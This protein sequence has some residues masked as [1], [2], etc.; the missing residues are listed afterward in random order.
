MNHEQP[1][2]ESVVR[3]SIAWPFPPIDQVLKQQYD[4]PPTSD[5]PFTTKHLTEE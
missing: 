3:P 1:E 2:S 5:G 4:Q